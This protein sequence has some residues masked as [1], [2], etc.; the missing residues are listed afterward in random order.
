M[1]NGDPSGHSYMDVGRYT[2][3][4]IGRISVTAG[5]LNNGNGGNELWLCKTNCY[6]IN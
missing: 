4:T 3:V 2:L 1:T 5:P 6:Q